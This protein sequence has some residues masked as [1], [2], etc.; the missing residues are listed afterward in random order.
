MSKENN[1]DI[2]PMNLIRPV[3]HNSVF[4]PWN[5]CPWNSNVNW[6]KKNYHNIENELDRDVKN[7]MGSSRAVRHVHIACFYC[8]RIFDFNI[9]E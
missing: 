3:Y 7:S 8:P 2:L 9:W 4:C 5:S 6:K 1:Q